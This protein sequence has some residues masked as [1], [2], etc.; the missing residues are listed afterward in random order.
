MFLPAACPGVPP[1]CGEGSVL[2]ANSPRQQRAR[3]N[4]QK[5]RPGLV[6]SLSA[7]CCSQALCERWEVSAPSASCLRADE[8]RRMR[9]AQQGP[10]ACSGCAWERQGGRRCPGA[11]RTAVPSLAALR[12]L[13]CPVSLLGPPPPCEASPS[14]PGVLPAGQA[15][16]LQGSSGHRPARWGAVALAKRRPSP[17][18][19]ELGTNLGEAAGMWQA[20]CGGA[21]VGL[22]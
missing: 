5:R 2:L 6:I 20:G 8:K 11:G 4:H 9:R 13:H 1:G 22:G 18:D 7:G 19:G 3:C 14:T 12:F 15:P 17:E 21:G 10:A 16:R